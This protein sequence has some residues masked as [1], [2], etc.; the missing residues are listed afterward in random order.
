MTLD[1]KTIL[2]EQ[3]LQKLTETRDSLIK[4]KIVDEYTNTFWS[5]NDET[6]IKI[7]KINEI[8]IDSKSF[9]YSGLSIN[10]SEESIDISIDENTDLGWGEILETL[11]NSRQRICIK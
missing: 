5:Y 3:E 1:E 9:S 2:V 8:F 4:E 10:V 7:K 11:E 6:F